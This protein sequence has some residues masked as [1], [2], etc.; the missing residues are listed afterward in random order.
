MPRSFCRVEWPKDR[1]PSVLYPGPTSLGRSAQKVR[2]C[3]YL[4]APGDSG[5]VGSRSR[6]QSQAFHGQW[7]RDP[8]PKT[9]IHA[10]RTRPAI[11][12]SVLAITAHLLTGS[13]KTPLRCRRIERLPLV[14]LA[15]LAWNRPPIMGLS[16]LTRVPFFTFLGAHFGPIIHSLSR[17]SFDGSMISQSEGNPE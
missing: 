4:T 2:Y 9:V 8:K 15:H 11:V 1:C 6:Q 12:Q 14:I 13:L 3:R 16:T 5:S 17:F 10:G 7:R